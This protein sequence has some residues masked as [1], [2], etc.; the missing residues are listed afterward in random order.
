MVLFIFVLVFSY[1][2]AQF[3]EK[4]THISVRI[5]SLVMGFLLLFSGVYAPVNSLSV[6]NS[7]V[8]TAD[9][10]ASD[11][12][13]QPLPESTIQQ[14]EAV[15]ANST[16]IR[17]IPVLVTSDHLPFFRLRLLFSTDLFSLQAPAVKL[18]FPFLLPLFQTVF[19]FII[20]PNA[21]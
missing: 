13:D 10:A 20:S 19:Q 11:D 16:A 9:S 12:Q 5:L 17:F 7:A 14:W 4:R 1:L 21:P 3:M 18:I 6:L 2:C 15:T 8:Q